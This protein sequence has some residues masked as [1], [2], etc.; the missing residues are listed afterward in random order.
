MVSNVGE[1]TL[2]FVIPSYNSEKTIM[3]TIESLP[4]N[5]QIIVVDDCSTDKSVE[6]IKKNKKR[7]PNLKLIINSRV[8][9][10]AYTRNIGI[11]NST[12]E[13]IMLVDDD[14]FL[15]KNCVE[16]LMRE[17]KNVDFVCP[18]IIFENGV[19]MHPPEGIKCDKY[20]GITAALMIK[21]DSLKKLDGLFDETYMF[22]REDSDF[23]MRCRILGLKSKFVPEAVAVHTL[24]KKV[25]NQEQKYYFQVRNTI[26]YY[27]K[28]GGYGM[29]LSWLVRDLVKQLCINCLMNY[30]ER[31][32][33][34]SSVHGKGIIAKLNL[35]ANHPKMIEKP[36]SV[37]LKL[38][39]RAILWNIKNYP[40]TVKMSKKY[41]NFRNLPYMKNWSEYERIF[42]HG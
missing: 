16:N 42:M 28:F 10:P 38:Y 37:L 17:I 25:D 27:L 7:F 12:G 41:Q 4:S 21:N 39:L 32:R 40:N 2:S 14:V 23:F 18:R 13:Y 11:E 22:Y 26:Y 30:S 3:Q 35:L 34:Q 33:F 6:L 29:P 24:M 5:S 8:R 19:S 20:G 9:W 15:T 36:R 1:N 31:L